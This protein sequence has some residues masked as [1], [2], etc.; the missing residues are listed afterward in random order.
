[1][2]LCALIVSGCAATNPPPPPAPAL[3]VAAQPQ[4]Q[5]RAQVPTLPPAQKPPP[6]STG[7]PGTDADPGSTFDNL[8]VADPGLNGQ[9]PVLRVGSEMTPNNLLAVFAG[10]K[11][12]TGHRLTLNVETIYT[13]KAGNVLNAGS[14]IALVLK[15]HEEKEYRS[16]SISEDATDF[17]IR[18][19]RAP[20]PAVN[21]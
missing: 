4:V 14:W 21:P 8:D 15:P 2:G 5:P 17:L 12:R 6:A 1:M 10:L 18:V 7:N 3:P 16:A 13:D 11:N 9:L 20:I 19:Q